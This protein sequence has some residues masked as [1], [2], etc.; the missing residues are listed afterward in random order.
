MTKTTPFRII[1]DA[2]YQALPRLDKVRY[3]KSAIEAHKILSG[4]I[5]E[6]P[7]EVR[8][9]SQPPEHQSGAERQSGRAS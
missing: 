9:E 8:L 3:L 1:S 5:A 6:G 4:Q 2:E 7:V